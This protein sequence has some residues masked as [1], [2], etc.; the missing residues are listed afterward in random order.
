MSILDSFD[1][2]T[3][4]LISPSDFAPPIPGFPAVAVVCFTER[5]RE[6]FLSEYPAEPITQMLSGDVVTVYQTQYRDQPIAFYRS[7]V[8]G[9]A[10]A[11][12]M[13]AMI[14]KGCKR[15]V[16]FGACGALD[17]AIAPHQLI[18]PTA[19]YRDEGASYHYA[20]ASDWMEVKTADRLCALLEGLHVPYLRSKV[21]TTD[22][23]FRETRG[24]AERRKQAGC[25]TVE[26][27]CASLMAA[28]QFRG[29][30][31]YQFLHAADCLDGASW[32]ART[33]GSMPDGARSRI[34]RVAME[35]GAR[36]AD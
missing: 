22:A 17:A 16:F 19:A 28:S 5:E 10:T 31:A 4:A 12:L 29:I 2:R 20:P 21:W 13:D 23:I 32:D 27:E 36:L 24:V 14:A 26:M 8:G 7:Q 15:F 30:E 1:D 6:I 35:V 25:L 11:A 33:L 34:L 18:V 3:E 9:A